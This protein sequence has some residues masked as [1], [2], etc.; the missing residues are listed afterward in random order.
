MIRYAKMNAENV[1][2]NIIVCDDFT[3][4][5]MPGTY[6]KIT[7]NTNDTSIGYTYLTV[8][9]KFIKPK[10]YESWV[11]NDNFD[12]ESPEGLNPDPLTKMWDENTLSWTD[13]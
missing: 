5:S 1:V 3:I 2:E 13:R 12:W 7:E 10:P 6:I 8:E 9:N 11:L 4:S